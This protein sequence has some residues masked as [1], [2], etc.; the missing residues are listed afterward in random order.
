[1]RVIQAGYRMHDRIVRPA[2]VTVSG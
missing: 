2:L 1:V